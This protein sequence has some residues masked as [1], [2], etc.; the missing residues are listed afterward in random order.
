MSRIYAHDLRYFTFCI[1]NILCDLVP[2]LTD[3]LVFMGELDRELPDSS[4]VQNEA[5]LR[6]TGC[7][8]NTAHVLKEHCRGKQQTHDHK[9]TPEDFEFFIFTSCGNNRGTGMLAGLLTCGCAP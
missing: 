7:I 3:F 1:V 4:S 9:S 5:L 8:K 2:L 6:W